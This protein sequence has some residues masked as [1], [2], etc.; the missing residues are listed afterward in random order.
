MS[1]PNPHHFHTD[2]PVVHGFV[3][4]T[5][6]ERRTECTYICTYYVYLYCICSSCWLFRSRFRN[7]LMQ[8]VDKRCIK[9]AEWTKTM[10]QPEWTIIIL[11]SETCAPTLLGIVCILPDYQNTLRG[12]Y[13][14]STKLGHF[15]WQWTYI[16]EWRRV[17]TR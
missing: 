2:G 4:L 9:Y 12:L 5:G 16:D 11:E 3:C 8:R 10:A 17:V 1:P 7:S 13:C 6:V 15:W 14:S